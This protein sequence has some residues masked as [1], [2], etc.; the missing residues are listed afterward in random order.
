MIYALCRDFGSTLAV[1]FRVGFSFLTVIPFAFP[2]E[3]CSFI[4]V[5]VVF[6]VITFLMQKTF[7][8]GN[9]DGN[10]EKLIQMPFLELRRADT[11]TPT[12]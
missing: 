9:G 10:S 1:F 5:T 6:E 3:A 11:Q 4:V 2:A 12:R 7:Q 8:D